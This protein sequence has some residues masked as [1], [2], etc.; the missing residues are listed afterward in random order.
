[1]LLNEVSKKTLKK[2]IYGVFDNLEEAY[3]EMSILELWNCFA[4]I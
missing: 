1:M 2:K 4:Q 3:D